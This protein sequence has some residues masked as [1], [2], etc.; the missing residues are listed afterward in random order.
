MIWTKRVVSQTDIT[1]PTNVKR[2]IAIAMAVTNGGAFQRNSI[3]LAQAANAPVAP[4]KNKAD[5][6]ALRTAA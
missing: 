4:V 2:K 5:R 3:A 6:R 1:E